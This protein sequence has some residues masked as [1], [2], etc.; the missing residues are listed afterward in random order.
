VELC[1]KKQTQEVHFSYEQ[2][3]LK[4]TIQTRSIHLE[5][6]APFQWLF[7]KDPTTLTQIYVDK[8]PQNIFK[9]Y[10]PNY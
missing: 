1:N 2:H 9:G 5:N 7:Q 4:T 3:R 10:R 8:Y 6:K